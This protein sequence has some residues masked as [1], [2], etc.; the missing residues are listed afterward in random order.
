MNSE[1]D[2]TSDIE[3]VLDNIRINSVILSNEH[4]NKYFHLKTILRYFR[5][6]V[7]IISGINSIVSVGLQPYVDQGI[8]SIMTCLLALVCSIIGSIEL[9]LAIQKGME[10]E[11]VVSK[12]YYI[13][14]VDIYKTLTLSKNHRPIPAKDYLDKK[15][16]DYIKLFE[17][18]NLLAKE[19]TDKLNPLPPI[20]PTINMI[21][22][23]IEDNI[24]IN[25]NDNNININNIK[26]NKKVEYTDDD[27]DNFFKLEVTDSV[28]V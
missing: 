2:W 1:T 21:E 8:I 22:D 27:I 25:I 10:N 18:S 23:K 20:P 28:T 24:A 16:N 9:Y 14:S 19:L 6:P 13:L 4:K 7:I 17:N 11:L 5:L 12:D 26:N 3:N 15:Y